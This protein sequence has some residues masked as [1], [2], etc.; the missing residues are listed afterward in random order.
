MRYLSIVVEHFD[1]LLGLQRRTF[2]PRL[3]VSL[4]VLPGRRAGM[5][6]L[7]SALRRLRPWT[8]SKLASPTAGPLGPAG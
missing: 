6:W 4:Q 2:P 7:V 1:D 5:K 8:W 3:Q